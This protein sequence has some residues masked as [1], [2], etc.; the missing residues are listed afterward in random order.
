MKGTLVGGVVLAMALSAC[1]STPEQEIPG[2]PPGV[3]YLS[4]SNQHQGTG[5]SGAQPSD[6]QQ[7]QTG[8][9]DQ[10]C[11]AGRVES[12][13]G[14][15]GSDALYAELLALSGARQQRVLAP[16]TAATMDYRDDRLNIRT[17]DKGV[18]NGLDCG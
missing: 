5:A 7:T 1:S 8:A 9:P 10:Q 17:D 15:T 3:E 11:D 6:T 12:Y 13:V 18:I 2:A 14:Q 16:H 4:P